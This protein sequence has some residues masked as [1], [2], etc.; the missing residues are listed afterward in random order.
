MQAFIL[1]AGE[2]QRLLP[3]T[4]FLPK[5]L[6]P[7][8]GKPILE[9]ILDQL[10]YSGFKKVGI[11]VYHLKD[12]IL[13]FIKDYQKRNPQL[14]IRVFVE[15]NLLGTGGALLNAKTF[16]KEPTLIVNGDILTNFPLEKLYLFHLQQ[17]SPITMLC[18]KGYNNNV[19][20]E[21]NLVKAF[22]KSTNKSYT[23]AGIQVINPEVIKYFPPEKD[24]IKIY[25]NLL[26]KNF[27]IASFL[28]KDY[29]FKDVGTLERYLSSFEDLLTCKVYIP[30]INNFSSSQI[31]KCKPI[32]ENLRIKNWVYLEEETLIESET[33]ISRVVSWKGAYIP[34][35]NY[36]FQLFI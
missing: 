33:F 32:P 36:D 30:F 11:N 5:P 27:S 4:K 35:G 7:V 19:E 21:N 10:Y 9:I 15:P 8:L 14:E 31:I 25:Q 16:F 29:Y 24:L 23:Y 12:K 17:K 1:S 18:Y 13:S 22:R 2:G 34:K 26:T 3:Y 20:I 6:F 28:A